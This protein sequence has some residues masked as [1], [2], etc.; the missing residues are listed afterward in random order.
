MPLS[1]LDGKPLKYTGTVRVAREDLD[2]DAIDGS[3][4]DM[5][6]EARAVRERAARPSP[7]PAAGPW[8]CH[9]CTLAAGTCEHS[10]HWFAR[11]V[12][13]ARRAKDAKLDAARLEVARAVHERRPCDPAVGRDLDDAEDR[14]FLD[15]IF[16]VVSTLPGGS[17]VLGYD[18]G[19]TAAAPSRAGSTP[20]AYSDAGPARRAKEPL[21]LAWVDVAAT[22][23]VAGA[24]RPSPRG[25]HAMVALGRAALVV[26]GRAGKG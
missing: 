14:L 1:Y 18:D 17:T 15:D 11:R 7:R 24:G 9:V 25:G 22:E 2:R 12:A 10:P 20:S 21:K 6:R 4:L 8:R 16:D 23:E 3:I 13:D 19:A 5:V 26:Y